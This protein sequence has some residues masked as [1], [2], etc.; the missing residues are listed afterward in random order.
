QAER[1]G[2]LLTVLGAPARR[3]EALAPDL[4]EGEVFDV[5]N[6]RIVVVPE[7]HRLLADRPIIGAEFQVAD[8]ARTACYASQATTP[9]PAPGTGRRCVVSPAQ[10]HGLW[11]AFHE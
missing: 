3:Q 7:R 2:R 6:G 9:S 8:L 4:V 5:Q 1:F 10:A 11:L